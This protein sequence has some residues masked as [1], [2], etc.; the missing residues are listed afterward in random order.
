[1]PFCTCL[2]VL[3]RCS[4]LFIEMKLFFNAR[5]PLPKRH[6]SLLKRK[7][8]GNQGLQLRPKAT[9]LPSRQRKQKSRLQT[10]IMT[11]K[12]TQWTINRCQRE[13]QL[14]LRAHLPIKKQNL[15]RWKIA[16]HQPT[17]LPTHWIQKSLWKFL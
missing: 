12:M 16:Y 1:M 2:F 15:S 9:V 10:K 8:S 4:I 11:K 3:Y 5:A 14:F 6:V 17:F 13:L 7:P